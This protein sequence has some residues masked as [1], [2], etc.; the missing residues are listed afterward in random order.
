MIDI[1]RLTK[2]ISEIESNRT[3]KEIVVTAKRREHESGI[4]YLERMREC[5]RSVPE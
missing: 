1:V 5:E 2:A 3:G 4:D